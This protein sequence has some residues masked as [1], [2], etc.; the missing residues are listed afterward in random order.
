MRGPAV[1]WKF[2]SNARRSPTVSYRLRGRNLQSEVTAPLVRPLVGFQPLVR[3][4][5]TPFASEPTLL[6]SAR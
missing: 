2:L 1:L 5:S 4:E 6:P 3:L